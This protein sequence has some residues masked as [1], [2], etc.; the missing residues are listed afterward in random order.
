[1]R[2]IAQ[3]IYQFILL[4]LCTG[5]IGYGQD[6]KFRPDHESKAYYSRSIK[7]MGSSS[8][9][10][11]LLGT[12][13]AF[14]WFEMTSIPSTWSQKYTFKSVSNYIKVAI[15]H[16]AKD[17]VS[18]YKYQ[19]TFQVKGYSDPASPGTYTTQNHIITL[20]YNKDSLAAYKDATL[21]KLPGSGFYSFDLT[22]IDVQE[23]SGSSPM[24]VSKS[25]LAPNFYILAEVVTQRYDDDLSGKMIFVNSAYHSTSQELEVRWG[26]YAP[27][28]VSS[29]PSGFMPMYDNFKPVKYELE[30]TYIDDY[31]LNDYN[32]TSGSAGYKNTASTFS[33]PYNFKNNATRIQTENNYF[34]IP[35]VYGHGAVVFRVRR[36]RPD[37]V[38]FTDL[39]YSDW[40]LPE[41][42]TLTNTSFGTGGLNVN[43]YRAASNCILIVDTPHQS[44]SVNY[45]YSISFAEE[46][47]YKHVLNYFDG[48]G[49]NRQ[50]QTKINSDLD[51][52]VAV[53][54]I[55]DFEGRPAITTLPT[56]VLSSNLQFKSNLSL[57]AGTN[58]PYRAPDF[59]T[60]CVTDTVAPF[61][62][63]ALASVYYSDQNTDKSGM[64]KFVPDAGGYPFI[65]TIYSPDYTDKV[66]W[67]GGAG[68]TFQ[69][70]KD[71]GTRYAYVRAGQNELNRLFGTE[72][73][74]FQYYPKQVTVDPN[75]QASF[76]IVHP[77][78]KT[79]ATALAGT[80]PSSLL[81]PIDTLADM[82][83]ATY[84]VQDI[85][86]GNLQ[87][88][89][90]GLRRAEY[91]YYNEEVGF[92]GLRYS[93]D[94]APFPTGCG[95]QY[96]NIAGKLNY[97]IIDECGGIYL[98]KSDVAGTNSVTTSNQHQYYSGIKDS[99]QLM[100]GKYTI[101]KE[102]SFPDSTI[103]SMASSFVDNN[104]GN[105]LCYTGKEV[106]IRSE[107]ENTSFPCPPSDTFNACDALRQ[108]LKSELYPGAKYGQ[109]IKADDG[110][111][112][113][114][115]GNSIFTYYDV[116]DSVSYYWEHTDTPKIG[117][118]C[119]YKLRIDDWQDEPT[120]PGSNLL[121]TEM[122][123]DN[124]IPWV[125]YDEVMAPFPQGGYFY[126]GSAPYKVKH[127]YIDT[128]YC[129]TK[130]AY[131]PNAVNVGKCL[132]HVY[133]LG[134]CS[135][136]GSTGGS[137][138]TGTDKYIWATSLAE[139]PTSTV[140]TQSVP[141]GNFMSKVT[142]TV[143]L[144][145]TN[146]EIIECNDGTPYYRY[147][148]PCLNSLNLQLE[149]MDVYGQTSTLTVALEDA[150]PEQLIQGFND[151]VA[152]TLLSL[153]PEYCK[154]LACD[155]GN[156]EAR[157]S[158][159]ETYDQA[160][161]LGLHTL[162]GIVAQDP[163]CTANKPG[164]PYSADQLSYFAADGSLSASNAAL[165][166]R[167]DS[168]AVAQAYCGC[169]SAEATV[170][171]REQ[172]Y[173]SQISSM[174]LASKEIKDLYIK[175]LKALYLAN[176]GLLKQRLTDGATADCGPCDS[177]RMN[178]IGM[179][180]FTTIFD[181]NGDVTSD[182]IDQD[183]KDLIN[184]RKNNTSDT[185]RPA[186]VAGMV[187]GGSQ[188][189]CKHQIAIIMEDLKSCG[190]LDS[191]E[192]AGMGTYLESF[193]TGTSMGENITPD[194]IKN[195]LVA[196][197]KYDD[198]CGPFLTKYAVFNK[199]LLTEKGSYI[200]KS[201]EFYQG[202]GDF[203]NRIDVTNALLNAQATGSGSASITITNSNVF[204]KALL[205]RFA[206]SSGS[207]IT[208]NGFV[209]T[210]PISAGNTVNATVYKLAITSGSLS[211]TLFL[212]ERNVAGNVLASP[213][214]ET[215]PLGATLFT[216]INFS[217]SH[218]L[219]ADSLTYGLAEGGVADN[220]A[221]ITLNKQVVVQ[222]TGA[223]RNTSTLYNIWSHNLPMMDPRSPDGVEECVNCELLRR[224]VAD[225]YSAAATY[226]MPTN[227]AHPFFET[228][229]QNYLN[230]KLG[231]KHGIEQ[232]EALAAGCGLTDKIAI[233]GSPATVQVT[234]ATA[235]ATD[236]SPAKSFVQSLQ[237]AFPY[238]R[239]DHFM[240]K[241]MSDNKVTVW[242]DLATISDRD[243]IR[244]LRNYIQ[245]NAGAGVY[246]YL[247]A[248]YSAEL[249]KQNGAA[250][251]I[252][253]AT[254]SN[255]SVRILNQDGSYSDAT[256]YMIDATGT[257][258]ID[259]ASVSQG[260]L[261][262]A[263]T[264]TTATYI[265]IVLGNKLYRSS[266]YNTTDKQAY[267]TYVYGLSSL[268][269]S[270]VAAALAP[271]TLQQQISAFSST[272][273][274][275]SYNSPWCTDNKGSLYYWNKNQGSHAGFL[276]LN[277]VLGQVKTSLGSNKL[278]PA[279]A[280]VNISG[281]A[282]SGNA[283]VKAFRQGNG[284]AWYRIFDTDN[285]LYN[286]YI[287]PSV[288]M[289]GPAQ[290]YAMLS[291]SP[292]V[293]TTE[294]ATDVYRFNV[295][296][297][298]G[299]DTVTVYG[300]TD[301]PIA[302]GSKLQ[303]VVLQDNYG[304][305]LQCIDTNSCEHSSLLAAVEQ[306]TQL[307][308]AYIDSVKA[309]LAAAMAWF[310]P[311]NA[312]DTLQHSMQSQQYHYTL[313][314]YDL[315]G[316]LTRTVPP[317]GV[318][319]LGTV[320]TA[321]VDGARNAS[322]S[323]TNLIMKAEHNKT[324]NYRYNSFN[325]LVWQQT[326]DGGITEFFYDKAGRLVF[327]QNAVQR[328]AK[329]YSYTLYDDQ[330]RVVET[331]QITGD[332]TL[333][334]G[335]HPVF[336]TNLFMKN[337][338][339]A[340]SI[341][342]WV[343]VKV[344]EEV[345]ATRYDKPLISLQG[346]DNML[347]EQ[348]NL[349]KRV[350]AILYSPTVTT[351]LSID[352]Y[353]HYATHFSYD[354]MGNVQT[355]THDNPYLDYMKQRFK[356]IDYDY[357]LLSGKVN[358][359]SYN[360]GFADQ[361]YQ[362]YEYDADNRLV[363]T[364]SSKD[365]VEWDRDAAY[366]YYKHGPL[367][368]VQYGDLNVQGVQYAYTIQGWLKAI[369]GDGLTVD[370]DMGHNGA[371]SVYPADV[372]SH[373]LDYYASDYKAIDPAASVSTLPD[374]VRSLYNGNIVRQATATVGSP[375]MVRDY[376][377]DQLHR[378]KK[379]EYSLYDNITMAMTS[380]V[381]AYKN[382]YSYDP[383]GN[384]QTLTRNDGAGNP[385]DNL[386]YHY[387]S[388][389]QNNKLG[390]VADAVPHMGGNDLKN[391]QASGN[392][393]YDAIGN[394]KSDVSEGIKDI[395]WNV[396]GKMQTLSK[397]T[398]QEDTMQLQ[399]AY[400]GMGNRT[401]KDYWQNIGSGN[402]GALR[403]SDIYV[404]DAQGNIL[405]VYK[406]KAKINGSNTIDWL[407]DQLIMSATATELAPFYT[408]QV[409]SN[410]AFVNDFMNQVV[411]TNGSWAYNKISSKSTAYFMS[412]SQPMYGQALQMYLPTSYGDIVATD[413]N[414]IGNAFMGTP[415]KTMRAGYLIENMTSPDNDA[416][417][418]SQ[419]LLHLVTD[420]RAL[421]DD[422]LANMGYD[423]EGLTEW[424]KVMA[425]QNFIEE[426]GSRDF[427]NLF[428]D[429]VR[430][431]DPSPFWEN[432]LKDPVVLR[433]DILDNIRP[434][435]GALIDGLADRTDGNN[436]DLIGYMADWMDGNDPGVFLGQFSP[437]TKL[438]VIYDENKPLFLQTYI[439]TYG[440][441][442]VSH[443]I[444]AIPGV[445][446]ISLNSW[447]VNAANNGILPMSV[448]Q[449][450]NTP[451][452]QN[453]DADTLYLAEHHLYG[454]SRLGIK[455]YQPE[456]YWNVYT[457]GSPVMQGA[458]ARVPWYSLAYEEMVKKS[459][460][461]P[462]SPADR[463]VDSFATV[464]TLG[465]KEYEL[466]D[467]LGNVLANV[468]DRKTGYGAVNNLYKGFHADVSSTTDYYPFGFAI[469][470]RSTGSGGRFGYNGK[471]NVDELYG[472]GNFQDY[473]MRDYDPRIARFLKVDPL[474]KQFPWYSS[475][476]FAGN[477]PIIAIDLDGLEP[478][479]TVKNVYHQ[480]DGTIR[481]VADVHIVAKVINMSSNKEI[482]MNVVAANL[483]S[484]LISLS[485][486][487]SDIIS[488]PFTMKSNGK[489]SGVPVPSNV[490]SRK[491]IYE[492]N[493]TADVRN[494]NDI[495]NLS[496]DD[497]VLALV[498][499]VKG[500]NE[501]ENAGIAN[502]GGKV[503]LAE[504]SEFGYGNNAKGIALAFHEFLHL[505]GAQDIYRTG[506]DRKDNVMSDK[507]GMKLEEY[508]K[509]GIW[510]FTIGPWQR[511]WMQ[512][513]NNNYSRP[514]GAFE[515]ENTKKQLQDFKDSQTR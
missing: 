139:I 42:G 212:A 360:R 227:A 484:S 176:R 6:I 236:F 480:S 209:T 61:A 150:S 181:A 394:L 12:T 270:E 290:E 168:M 155:T 172:Q 65:Q 510:N 197:G 382:T 119:K 447:I 264:D 479:I 253:G 224:A 508:Q 187:S 325:Q 471:E 156:F 399:F 88:I 159:L 310:Y 321:A 160:V 461:E 451:N 307:H 281:N 58:Q 69:R 475:Y 175:S 302:A 367:A 28:E 9:Y 376:T 211:D 171:C 165:L 203:M 369:N 220:L 115:S 14:E 433:Q 206:L 48:M 221:Y 402:T 303:D 324:S 476:Q 438:N 217:N 439:G 282:G 423:P 18:N 295:L 429:R 76:A 201:P 215:D 247:P 78:G 33:V 16:N 387:L 427:G 346:F 393:T 288:K 182:Y 272:D 392:Y 388:P 74:Y 243:T 379:T 383:D 235:G 5:M 353:Y 263:G 174:T 350:S 463:L 1:M 140:V 494:V 354:A 35:V 319:A 301:F 251:A 364:F 298:R 177:F 189:F 249:F 192:L 504:A 62:S 322:S 326:P 443:A 56:P 109:Y 489:G 125:W 110:S 296:M 398:A 21:L 194:I 341:A 349:R 4:V 19:L 487:S 153:H 240:F 501:Q 68:K 57:H 416:E 299:T 10:N 41:S 274:K 436:E 107:I 413:W 271:A 315:A 44:D 170:Y 90:K 185:S 131:Y 258:P 229:L 234:F 435:T 26:N 195:K 241:N 142:C 101:I 51:Y 358:M 347:S 112:I 54:K 87:Q 469:S 457:P 230:Y 154:L 313:Y 118:R 371:D 32:H 490:N 237:Q 146:Y 336:I 342:D 273:L 340:G 29:L 470:E 98:S 225:Y 420:T 72:A 213:L 183:V 283:S 40:N 147:Q 449:F 96:I 375:N 372:M 94:I 216:Y 409:G 70:G 285:K 452:P 513:R 38:N 75:G 318:Q 441:A 105:G 91:S 231:K 173:Q 202:L 53:D 157:L 377:Y 266:D 106:F 411:G 280:T 459:V 488:L 123:S 300:Y 467:H 190:N 289:A 39:V 293:Y 246:Q 415:E 330:S 152:E 286:I 186:M 242:F 120:V 472:K 403:T 365:G 374:P 89:D 239:I 46:G 219:F 124:K 495:K 50:T 265:K 468:L 169:N 15:D 473:G 390:Y 317:A 355:L 100:P 460:R 113:A 275:L 344:R 312:I 141:I 199:K 73:G 405:A 79:V 218:N 180:N 304:Q 428:V 161:S 267:L 503:A 193:C 425:M 414:L 24:A 97:K 166:K 434:V 509:A 126:T 498:D 67:Q 99:V 462:Q 464:R 284:N 380:M 366:A 348:E 507:R 333:S 66:L 2:K 511:V 214:K 196:M 130:K 64:Q 419:T 422:L 334:V 397:G 294:G 205:T 309:G 378:I 454:S 430:D 345:V 335:Q 252:S 327:S 144:D 456:Q 135:V 13:S 408:N 343:K 84:K 328:A 133:Y 233:T 395:R 483:R 82:A 3:Y 151:N 368:E 260:V 512:V 493:V 259:K 410:G 226:L 502:K 148:V 485:G 499:D 446:A 223:T 111:F 352:S 52:V 184:S 287:T 279:A 23:I 311:K 250:P 323:V 7:T 314:Y 86:A 198:M 162:S 320:A 440:I 481:V 356:R 208:I 486:A 163:L 492:V 278:F 506:N 404:R 357:D 297:A 27:S 277:T 385:L 228:S 332:T 93:A 400:D 339:G 103:R 55:Y 331:G 363:A 102:L 85:L 45:Q 465:T 121:L 455:Y 114:G 77:A 269:E 257:L 276:R 63:G 458:S 384:I 424:D 421:A 391:N 164:A 431:Y 81:Y 361:F 514:K 137:M 306:G 108:R 496:A 25:G 83:A 92:N 47:K 49:K 444:K 362:R 256:R 437:A 128:L 22:L 448:M 59:D 262:F 337:M 37:N 222:S 268:S 474:S 305:Q 132:Y 116:Y 255:Q 36:I 261:N 245:T 127:T 104:T 179:P 244:N 466:T 500:D 389:T 338:N 232:Y 359:L 450:V 515:N 406:E 200:A 34:F 478:F 158:G 17:V 191:A 238:V 477:S 442:D 43:P 491:V 482:D 370:R 136:P 329:K 31:K 207:S 418:R 204:E 316:N 291:V 401:R 20:E 60:G 178:M 386:S 351:Q 308:F 210:Y 497:W 149:Q 453:I 71:H 145:T 8:G 254:V 129:E 248:G 11:D 417:S 138:A 134:N 122:G 188:D 396:Y 143:Y 407:N 373:T 30:W 80:S 505:L 426:H 117:D 381:D 167:F 412:Q 292:S 95:N 445:T 432:M